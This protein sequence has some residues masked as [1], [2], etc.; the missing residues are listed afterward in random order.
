MPKSQL[1]ELYAHGIGVVQDA[2]LEFGPGFNVITGETGAGKTL[3]LGALELCL[4]GDGPAGRSSTQE[5]LRAAAVFSLG[6][7]EIVLTRETSASGRLRSA[8]DGV[9][10]SAEALRNL[11]SDLIV[12]HGQHDSLTLR[13]RSEIVRIV[14]ASGGVST[15]ELD[16]TRLALR[17]AR[18]RRATLGGDGDERERELDFVSFQIGELEST[19][20]LSAR[21][22]D[23]TL[24][25][26]TRLTALR[27]GQ[28]S[29]V[30]VLDLLDADSDT[31]VLTLFSHAISRLPPAEA[32][33][34]PRAMLLGALEQSREGVHELASFANVD[35]FD[36]F[37]LKILEDRATQLQQIARK[38]GG[39]LAQAL[40]TLDELRT[41]RQQQLDA[42]S[43]SAALDDEILQLQGRSE[44]LALEARDA[45]ERAARSLTNAVANQLPRVAL[46]HA[47]LR[48]DVAGDDG[49]EMQILFSANPGQREGPL[50]TLASGGELSRVLLALSL[51]TAHE[52]VVTVFDEV[53]AGIGG[54]VAQQIGECLRE[55][56]RNRQVLAVT[57]LASVAAKADHHFVIDKSVKEGD[58]NTSVRLLEG[59][60]RVGEIA[61]MLAGDE[62]TSESWALAQQMLETL[63]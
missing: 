45:R 46:N 23:E 2:R 25:E 12:I 56:A 26:L 60:D 17:E 58:V 61:R 34:A 3:L 20:I 42:T 62:I 53:D 9:S 30:E 37:A 6:E 35:A 7:R 63:R 24:E 51:E 18:N 31:A 21:E 49:S 57:H 33:D 32:Y 43:L 54:Q 55:V 5:D 48:F 15:D 52:D 41:T 14:D 47:T 8:I 1:L 4:G 19:A 10:S 40:T 44:S 22:L 59:D 29:L 38:Y 27:D 13:Q 16:R 39:S 36:P 28:A 50:Q 11:A